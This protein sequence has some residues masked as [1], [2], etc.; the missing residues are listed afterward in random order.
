MK[1]VQ[2]H[3]TSRYYDSSIM[4]N[5][6]PVK[7]SVCCIVSSI[8]GVIS[9]SALS[10]YLLAGVFLSIILCTCITTLLLVKD[11]ISIDTACALPMLILCFVYTPI[12]WFSFQGL[13]GCTPYLS[14]L[15]LTII[16]LTY[17]NKIH[18]IM[19]FSYSLLLLGLI[20]NWFSTWKNTDQTMHAFNILLAYLITAI[21][22]VVLVS[23]VKNKN[24]QINRQ[25][26]D[27]SEKDELT[28]L[29]N[30]RTIKKRLLT[31]ENRYQKEKI[32]YAAIII[33][34]NQFKKINDQYGHQTGDSA[35]A[36]V[37]SCI[38]KSISA[39][40]YA[41]RFGGD[42]FL[43]ILSCEN[44]HYAEYLCKKIRQT[45]N[46]DQEY[47]F[48]VAIS[49]GYALRSNSENID[50]LLEQADLHMYQEKKE[51]QINT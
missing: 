10:Y 35:L 12:S 16:T 47:T 50:H 38:K 7:M 3:T 27:L 31:L 26:L 20:I 33:D 8:I 40:D 43:I 36:F 21:L 23:A 46:H 19:I 5:S 6:V 4:Q 1:T 51:I 48:H 9:M 41:F 39:S 34:L 32:D 15:F 22:N 24:I 49:S 18:K 37:A 29:Y 14:I 42:E 45:I 13:L 28:G 17:Y 30:R 11:K 2:N 25:I 44:E